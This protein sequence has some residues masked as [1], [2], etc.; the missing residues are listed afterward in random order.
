MFAGGGRPHVGDHRVRE[1]GR[2]RAITGVVRHA[3]RAAQQTDE[4]QH[5]EREDQDRDQRLEQV[6]AGLAGGRA[7]ATKLTASFISAGSRVGGVQRRQR[8][9]R[10][11]HPQTAGLGRVGGRGVVDDDAQRAPS[12]G[13]LDAMSICWM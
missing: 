13:T 6:A 9:I 10:V 7:I 4:A 8:G 3:D 2:L 1:I 12:A 11:A 5:A